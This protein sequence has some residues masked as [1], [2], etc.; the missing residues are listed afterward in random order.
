MSSYPNVH[1]TTLTHPPDGM[2]PSIISHSLVALLITSIS[3]KS[4][5]NVQISPFIY[6]SVTIPPSIACH[7]S[8]LYTSSIRPVVQAV[9]GCLFIHRSQIPHRFGASLPS[10]ERWLSTRPYIVIRVQSIGMHPAIVGH[11]SIHHASSM[12]QPPVHPPSVFRPRITWALLQP[13]RVAIHPL[14]F[15]CTTPQPAS[16]GSPASNVYR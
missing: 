6:P 12:R 11:S 13:L 16:I 2:R 7:A 14:L 5:P 1:L 10:A 9:C 8:V 15:R 4:Y 3:I